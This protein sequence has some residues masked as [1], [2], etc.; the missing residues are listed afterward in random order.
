MSLGAPLSAPEVEFLAEFENVT[1]M[2]NFNAAEFM[3]LGVRRAGKGSLAAPLT[4]APAAVWQGIVG[5]FQPQRPLAVPLWLAV[6]LRT[7]KKC[8]VVSPEWLAVDRLRELLAFE[9]ENEKY[10]SQVHPHLIEMA[11][12]LFQQCGPGRGARPFSP[13]PSCPMGAAPWRTSTRPRRCGR[14]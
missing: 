4:P 11:A 5:P 14:C 1:I 6:T 3:L 7:R 9:R 10:F 2:P 13:P 8:V 12:L